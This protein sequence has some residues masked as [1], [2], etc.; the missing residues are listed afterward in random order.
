MSTLNLSGRGLS[1]E[2]LIG[3]IR[4]HGGGGG[5][6]GDDVEILLLQGNRLTSIPDEVFNWFPNMTRLHLSNNSIT[7][8][9]SRIGTMARLVKVDLHNNPSLKALPSSIA[10]LA[11][12]RV[13]YAGHTGLPIEFQHYTN[14]GEET[15]LLLLR[16]G[17]HFGK[18]EQC[19]SR[20]NL[21]AVA[22]LASRRLGSPSTRLVG[23]DVTKM[24]AQMV[25][26]TRHYDE[27][28]GAGL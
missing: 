7:S 25:W 26:K 22:V 5:N 13:L 14:T 16:I 4:D 11:H 1:N 10:S 23:K 6:K 12:M 28:G 19:Q 18:I 3:F 20:C 24:I 2:A 8:V 15:Q 21:A 9:S 27:W 17:Q